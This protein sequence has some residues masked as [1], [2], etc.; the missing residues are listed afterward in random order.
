MLSDSA[1]K[2][3]EAYNVVDPLRKL[4]ARQATYTINWRESFGGNSSIFEL[5]IVFLRP[6]FLMS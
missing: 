1:V 5:A 6:P 2:T 4:T 3:T